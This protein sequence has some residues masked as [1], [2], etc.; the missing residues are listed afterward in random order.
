MEL[1]ST[2]FGIPFGKYSY[3]SLLGWKIFGKVP[4][5]IPVSWFFMSLASWLLAHQIL[6]KNRPVFLKVLVGSAL[7]LTWDFTLDPAMSQLTPF[8]V[9]EQS[10]NFVLH[11]PLRNLGGWFL[12]GCLIMTGYHLQLPRL[13]D[14]WK[15]K[16]FALKY[17]GANLLLPVGFAVVAGLWV[18]ILVTV[19]VGL[20]C[21]LIQKLSVGYN[22]RISD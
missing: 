13:P 14:L 8:W 9:W 3:T 6:G 4:F 19:F 22:F 15:D 12:T 18:P 10:Q 11:M 16:D 1:W 21:I 17:Y 2:S 7:L 20:I 5:W